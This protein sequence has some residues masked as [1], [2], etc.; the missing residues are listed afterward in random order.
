MGWPDIHWLARDKG[1]LVAASMRAGLELSAGAKSW[2][3]VGGA[4]PIRRRPSVIF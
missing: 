2:L 4:A 3:L 1:G